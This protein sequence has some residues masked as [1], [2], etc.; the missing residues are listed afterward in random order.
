VETGKE[1]YPK[2]TIN[3]NEVIYKTRDDL[4][5][6][7]I[8]FKLEND[9]L[10]AIE[11][12]ALDLVINNFL[13]RAKQLY[14]NAVKEN[15]D[16]LLPPFLRRYSAG[17]TYVRCLSH[18]VNVLEQKKN[19]SEAVHILKDI[20]LSQSVYCQDCRGRWFEKISSKFRKAFKRSK[21][22]VDCD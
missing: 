11:R 10:S 14:G 20:L 3:R 9:I 22:C 17:H 7:T 8:A 5:N 12:K 6:Y 2:Y 1:V 13:N 4:I 16:S 18:C 21:I 15:S 19:H